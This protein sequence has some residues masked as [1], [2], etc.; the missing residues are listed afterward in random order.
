MRILAFATHHPVVTSRY[1]C[2]AFR[3]GGVDLR[4]VGDACGTRMNLWNREVAPEQE[5]VPDGPR[6]AW[7]P[8]WRPDL[9][10]S[11]EPEPYHHPRYADVPHVVYGVDNHLYSY[12]QERIA[13]Y[14]LAH[15]HG[16]IM[17]AQGDDVTWLPCGY[18]P[19]L[20][21]PSPIPWEQRRYDVSILG[22]AYPHR[23]QLVRTLRANLKLT[24]AYATGPVFEQYRDVYH[25][26]RI[27]LCASIRGDVAIRIFETGAMGCLVLSDPC[28]DFGDLNAQ[29]I[30]VYRVAAEAVEA[31][32]SLL[33]HPAEAQSLLARSQQ[34]ARPHTWDA[35][36]QFICG[37]YERTYGNG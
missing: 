7:W 1:L 21:T 19:V 33:A 20:F 35:R 2:N 17:P 24:M 37:W 10:V 31:V 23:V 5:W 34:W 26:T 22:T 6:D 25:D 18:D 14:F 9:V 30:V 29:G 36:A 32:R 15:R 16:P 11:F 4:S 12:R 3:R 28:H 8:D 13:H 27:S